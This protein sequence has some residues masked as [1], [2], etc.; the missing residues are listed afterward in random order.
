MAKSR[1]W[2]SLPTEIRVMI[3]EAIAQQKHAR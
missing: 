3:L 1:P 2:A